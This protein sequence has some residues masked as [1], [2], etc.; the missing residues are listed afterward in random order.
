MLTFLTGVYYFLFLITVLL[1]ETN[2]LKNPT[3]MGDLEHELSD[4]NVNVDEVA[5]KNKD[6]IL[7]QFAYFLLGAI[8]LFSSQWPIFLFML[9]LGLIPRKI[10]PIFMIKMDA[11]LCVILT[12]FMVINRYHL[13]LNLNPF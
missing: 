11:I 8:G 3:K 1:C 12:V 4:E 6:L 7:W 9:A 10:I 13:H 2:V 5:K